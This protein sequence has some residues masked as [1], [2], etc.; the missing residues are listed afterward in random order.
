MRSLCICRLHDVEAAKRLYAPKARW[1]AESVGYFI[2][3]VL[4][5][6][7]IFA[8]PSKTRM[9][10]ARAWRICGAIPK[11]YSVNH[12]RQIERGNEHEVH[13]IR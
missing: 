6:G 4:Q 3:A 11:L 7:F 5:G 13:D 10:F 9:S 8:K 2:Q 1:S 12:V